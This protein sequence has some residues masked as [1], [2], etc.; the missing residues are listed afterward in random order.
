[1]RI[2]TIQMELFKE[3]G[4]ADQKI[5]NVASVPKRSVFRYPGGKTWF[6]PTFRRWMQS[7]EKK[8]RHLVEPFA[9]GGI[10]ALTAAFENLAD[11]V[12]ITELDEDVAAVWETLISGDFEKLAKRILKFEL[13]LTNVERA[14]GKAPKDTPDKAF[15][16]IL[17]NRVSHGGIMAPGS[18][19]IKH[20]ENGKGVSSRWYPET[21]A[22]RICE[23]GKVRERLTFIH[24]CAFDI[25]PKYLGDQRNFIFLDPPYTAAGKKAG[26]RLYRYHQLDH[27]QLFNLFKRAK[28]EFLFTYDDSAELRGLAGQYGFD[29]ALIPMKNTH[30][31]RMEELIIGKNLKWLSSN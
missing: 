12:V 10:I 15:Q 24:G 13:T 6:V 8:P 14:L 21:L 30:H 5:V 28:A 19:L 4:Q 1:M 25:I 27:A 22:K 7:S 31:A 23:I 17:R 3:P 26:R 11:K 2:E 18:G 16:T 29:T 9:G 20:G